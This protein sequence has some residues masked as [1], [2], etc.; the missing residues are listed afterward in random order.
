MDMH[1]IERCQQCIAKEEQLART[2]ASGEAGEMHAQAAMLYRT[3]LALLK[4]GWIALN[5]NPESDH[6]SP[7]AFVLAAGVHPQLGLS[8]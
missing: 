6:S 8:G 5:S 1:A 3:Q 2:A 7:G 4:R